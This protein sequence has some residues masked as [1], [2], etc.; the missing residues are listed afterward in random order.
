MLKISDVLSIFEQIGSCVY[1]CISY[2]S[3]EEGKYQEWI[4][5]ITTPD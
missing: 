2:Q 5:S 3:T 1:T 4:Q